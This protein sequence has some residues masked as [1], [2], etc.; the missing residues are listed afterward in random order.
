HRLIKA[1]IPSQPTQWKYAKGWT[2]YSTD[3]Q[4]AISIDYPDE[5]VMVFDVETL[6]REGNFPVL[7]VA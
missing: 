2:K 6:V 7:A 5:Q 3:G 4:T 1:K